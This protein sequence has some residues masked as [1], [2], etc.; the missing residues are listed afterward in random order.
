[1]NS[2]YLLIG[3][4]GRS[5]TT[6]LCRALGL[7]P[8][9]SDVP[10]WRFLTDPDGVIDFYRQF[11]NDWGSP[12][13]YDKALKRLDHLLKSISEKQSIGGLLG[14]SKVRS[15]SYKYSGLNLAPMYSR[16]NATNFSPN[17][18]S[19]SQDFI[20]ALKGHSYSGYWVGMEL[21]ESAEISPGNIGNRNTVLDCCRAFLK[22]IA[23]DVCS[24]QN[25]SHYLEKNT[26]NILWFDELLEIIPDAKIVHIVRDPRDV[27]SS[28]SCQPWA[29]SSKVESA[30]IYQEL[31]NSWAKVKLRI[32]T[33]SYLEIKLETL[34]EDP[35]RTFKTI[36]SFYGVSYNECLLNIGLS[37][38]SIGRWMTDLT[39]SE[40]ISISKIVAPTLIS[41]S[42]DD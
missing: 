17:F 20:A 12:F 37:D 24:N 5:G 11:K 7:H 31:M 40:Q 23:D 16:T 22:N 28:F 18:D 35:E 8:E 27:I 26:W 21:F 42:Y 9:V 33:E 2:K 14:S 41:Y 19:I 13:H 38:S 1:M 15:L 25:V 30:Y 3:G 36:C 10:E 29:P 32:P 39:D 6:I 4:S 34:I